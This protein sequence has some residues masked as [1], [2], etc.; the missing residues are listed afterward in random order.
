MNV[1]LVFYLWRQFLSAA[2][3]AR[4]NTGVSSQRLEAQM[5]QDMKADYEMHPFAISFSR[6]DGPGTSTYS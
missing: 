2:S 5:K 4:E 6:A 3:K 1:M